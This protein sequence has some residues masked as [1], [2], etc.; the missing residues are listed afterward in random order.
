M[1][2]I[3]KF[4]EN[5]SSGNRVVPCGRMDMKLTVVCCWNFAYAPEKAWTYTFRLE[6]VERHILDAI[7]LHY[8]P[9][10]PTD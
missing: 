8:E 4:S 7:C 5:P 2:K 10:A 9:T 1:P 6:L 3:I